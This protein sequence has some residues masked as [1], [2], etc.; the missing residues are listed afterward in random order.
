MEKD[1]VVTAWLGTGTGIIIS[2]LNEVFGLIALIL[3]CIYTGFRLFRD[4]NKERKE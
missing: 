2:Q 1:S 4:V 3:T